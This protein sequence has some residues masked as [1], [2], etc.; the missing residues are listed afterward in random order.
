MQI[1]PPNEEAPGCPGE[2][3]DNPQDPALGDVEVQGEGER[4]GIVLDD[5]QELRG[6]NSS[7]QPGLLAQLLVELPAGETQTKTFHCCEIRDVE[8]SVQ[9]DSWGSDFIQLCTVLQA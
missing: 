8:R 6:S 3:Q 1:Y 7:N 4:V 2:H 5:D 9:K